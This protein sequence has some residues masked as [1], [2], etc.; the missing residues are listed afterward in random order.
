[1]RVSI[2]ALGFSLSSRDLN[3]AVG[4][5]SGRMPPRSNSQA[6]PRACVSLVRSWKCPCGR[7]DIPRD[8]QVIPSRRVE[9]LAT[10][11]PCMSTKPFVVRDARRTL[12]IADS[13][14]TYIY[15]YA[16]GAQRSPARRTENTAIPPFLPYSRASERGNFAHTRI[17]PSHSILQ[18]LHHA[19]REWTAGLSDRAGEWRFSIARQ[20]SKC[21]QGFDSL[22][23]CRG[24]DDLRESARPRPYFRSLLQALQ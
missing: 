11:A 22:G 24:F 20:G 1:M 10:Y 17:G 4:G 15:S 21:A 9:R 19:G 3:Y 13:P 2:Y 14:T 23:V 12:R 7:G 8:L 5:W 16:Y 6:T 18:L